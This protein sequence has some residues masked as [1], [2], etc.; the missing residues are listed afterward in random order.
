ML[1]NGV[2]INGVLYKPG[3]PEWTQYGA[4]TLTIGL[5]QQL[6]LMGPD[7]RKRTVQFLREQ[8]IGT[9]Q[10]QAVVLVQ[11]AE[12]S[13][14]HVQLRLDAIREGLNVLRCQNARD[15]A[16]DP[17]AK[18]LEAISHGLDAA[19]TDEALQIPRD[20]DQLSIEALLEGP[21]DLAENVIEGS[22]ELS[23]SFALAG[24]LTH[25]LDLALQVVRYLM[26]CV[27]RSQSS[28]EQHSIHYR[29]PSLA[30]VPSRFHLL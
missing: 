29:M 13:A 7:A 10:A 18:C 14:A 28:S 5:D 15:E 1:T 3:T 22:C 17:L 16:A 8:I 25:P 4:A 11:Q 19:L 21:H 2:T 9:A 23:Q 30:S 6:R 12:E 27:H 24:L 20:L 26:S